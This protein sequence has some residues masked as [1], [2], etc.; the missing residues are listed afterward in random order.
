MYALGKLY[1]FYTQVI[2]E[3]IGLCLKKWA[4]YLDRLAGKYISLL[5]RMKHEVYQTETPTCV[6]TGIKWSVRFYFHLFS[7]FCLLVYQELM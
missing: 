6:I 4:I 5:S 2:T 1:T 7:S 3:T